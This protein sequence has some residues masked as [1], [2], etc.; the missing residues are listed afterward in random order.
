MMAETF[1]KI[2]QRFEVESAKEEQVLC[3]G[4]S[5]EEEKAGE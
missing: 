1:G 4:K 2:Q 5:D 3:L